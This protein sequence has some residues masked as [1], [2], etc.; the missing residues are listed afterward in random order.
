MADE[1][2]TERQR[3][4]EGDERQRDAEGEADKAAFDAEA[5]ELFGDADDVASAASEGA[6]NS[7]DDIAIGTILGQT[8]Q[9]QTVGRSPSMGNVAVGSVHRAR[10]SHQPG[11]RHIP[12]SNDVLQ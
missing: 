9:R 2:E 1:L 10:R 5:E 3:D 11:R 4:A 12:E 7:D 6:E 8:G